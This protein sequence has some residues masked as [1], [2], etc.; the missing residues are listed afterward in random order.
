MSDAA[1]WTVYAIGLICGIIGSANYGRYLRT[2]C[3]RTKDGH[4]GFDIY[5]FGGVA[6]VFWPFVVVV[7]TLYGICKTISIPGKLLATRQLNNR[8][9]RRERDRLLAI[10]EELSKRYDY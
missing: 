4:D 1:I 5:I 7:L 8:A 2:T 6:S 10:A 9:K 3:Q